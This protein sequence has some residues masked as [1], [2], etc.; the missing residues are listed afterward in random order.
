VTELLDAVESA[1]SAFVSYAHEDQ[2]FV[3]ALIERLHGEGLGVRYDRVV[4]RI[5][6]SLIE[7]IST[8]IFADS[9]LIAVVSPD[10]V[11][12]GWCQKELS[13]AMTQGVNNK[14]VKVLPVKRRNAEMPP[15]LSDIYYADADTKNIETVAQE[16]AQSIRD[17]VAGATEAEPEQIEPTGGV[18]SEP[19]DR[20]S[21]L[22]QIDTVATRVLNVIAEWRALWKG[23]GNLSDIEDAQG[24]LRWAL[25]VLPDGV[26]EG[27]PAVVEF[28]DADA[29][30]FASEDQDLRTVED[31][32]REEMRSVYRQVE[33][34]LPVTKRWTLGSDLGSIPVRRD[35]KA[36]LWEIRRG[37]ETRRIQFFVSGTVLESSDE[38]LPPEVAEAKRTEGR[39]AVMSVLAMENPPEDVVAL[40]TGISFTLPD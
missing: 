7:R 25:D 36:R 13:I 28:A 32:L 14:R 8:A 24:H 12:S 3:L 34:G 15:M 1:P 33:Q 10:S 37:D 35:G 40:S 16:L 2:E 6:D 22:S 23:D 11:N 30:Y 20:A 5:G 38:G 17:H 39:S 26:T 4:L 19:Q 21:V 31:G 9:F 27:L 29:K 18:V